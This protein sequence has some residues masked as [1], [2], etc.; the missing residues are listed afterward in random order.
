MLPK[1]EKKMSL[2]RIA[3][4]SGQKWA[5]KYFQSLSVSA[6]QVVMW[7]GKPVQEDADGDCEK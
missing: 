5:A 4:F 2:T 1:R 3:S 6:A 7:A